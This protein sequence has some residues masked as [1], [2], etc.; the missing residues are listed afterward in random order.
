MLDD[1]SRD[2]FIVRRGATEEKEITTNG[3]YLCTFLIGIAIKESFGVSKVEFI[4]S[5]QFPTGAVHLS[6][7]YQKIIS[8][9]FVL[10]AVLLVLW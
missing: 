10:D 5:E 2:R 4:Q 9:K 8:R 1:K 7:V 3:K 6:A